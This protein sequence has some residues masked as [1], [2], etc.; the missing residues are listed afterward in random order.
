MTMRDRRRRSK[1]RIEGRESEEM[2]ESERRE[3]SRRVAS[4]RKKQRREGWVSKKSYRRATRGC[5]G[6]V[7]DLQQGV[8]LSLLLTR[9]STSI[10]LSLLL[11]RSFTIGPSPLRRCLSVLRQRSRRFASS[12]FVIGRQPATESR[13]LG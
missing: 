10:L 12:V 1:E 9:A 11:V 3:S 8:S 6:S 7:I 5:V 2:G 4:G 13:Q